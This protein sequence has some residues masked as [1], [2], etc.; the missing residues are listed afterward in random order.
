MPYEVTAMKLNA[1]REFGFDIEFCPDMAG[2]EFRPV[3]SPHVHK[4]V[5]GNENP[6]EMILF[7]MTMVTITENRLLA[8]LSSIPLVRHIVLWFTARKVHRQLL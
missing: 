7:L 3:G 5:I 8:A 6:G 1:K 4:F 2:N